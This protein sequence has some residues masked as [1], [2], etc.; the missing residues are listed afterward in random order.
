MRSIRTSIL[1]V[2]LGAVGAV[3]CTVDED[4][5]TVESESALPNGSNLNGSNL[6]GSNLN[7][8]NLN[9][10][11]LGTVL[12]WSSLANTSLDETWLDGS[13]LV[14]SL[15]GEVLRGGDMVG[16][17]FQSMSD[18][19]LEVTVRI[20]D[21]DPPD[22]GDQWHYW[23]EYQE[24]DGSWQPI[25]LDQGPLPATPLAGWWDRREAHP[26]GGEKYDDPTRFTFACALVGALGKCAEAGYRPWATVG[27]VD[28]AEHHQACV[29]LMRKDYCGDGTSHT[30]DGLLVNIYDGLGIQ[31]DTEEWKVEAE[32]DGDGAICTHKP[33]HHIGCSVRRLRS[34][35]DVAHF[36]TGT[37]LISERPNRRGGHGHHHD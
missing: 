21:V 26:L 10:S 30:T 37:L 17:T 32:W 6:N 25:C 3:G 29:R 16:T 23:V 13:E 14:G 19:G 11:E 2:A 36:D 24:T 34:C 31:P 8:S 5:G 12:V 27:G 28:L 22:T 35:G 9:G 33:V 18:L 20:A 1:I 7:G 4:L 15:D